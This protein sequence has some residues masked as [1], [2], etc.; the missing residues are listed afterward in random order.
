M[1]YDD[2]E[3]V[4]LAAIGRAALSEMQGQQERLNL[5]FQALTPQFKNR[6]PH[7]KILTDLCSQAAE[8]KGV[9]DACPG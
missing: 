1:D 3:T 4:V 9:E 5:L 7:L 6:Y 8:P 2:Y